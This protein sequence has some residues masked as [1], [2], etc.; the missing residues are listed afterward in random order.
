MQLFGAIILFIFLLLKLPQLMHML[1]RGSQGHGELLL[2]LP[3][4]EVSTVCG[5]IFRAGP[6]C[7]AY[8]SNTDIYLSKSR[9]PSKTTM[10]EKT[11][12][13]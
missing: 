11:Q 6:F 12:N 10:L 2:S 1:E 7:T 13:I 9:T 5:V 8:T 4:L 3:F